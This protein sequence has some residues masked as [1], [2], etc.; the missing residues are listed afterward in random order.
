MT[1]CPA[2][3]EGEDLMSPSKDQARGAVVVFISWHDL[4]SLCEPSTT[5]VVINLTRCHCVLS[6]C[7]TAESY[8][9]DGIKV[10]HEPC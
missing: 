9:S 10:L 2:A 5:F 6:L 8:F 7:L 1:P 3:V 4:P